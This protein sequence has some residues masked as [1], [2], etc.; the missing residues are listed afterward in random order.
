MNCWLI[1]DKPIDKNIL[2]T[3]FI[4]KPDMVEKGLISR[5]KGRLVV[6]GSKENN[7]QDDIFSPVTDFTVAR[8]I[9][10]LSI[11]EI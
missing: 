4:L 9:L 2:N 7:F 5:H 1:V 3:K 11:E 10:C 6:C 8:V